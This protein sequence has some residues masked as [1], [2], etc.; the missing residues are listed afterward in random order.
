MI[1][2][3]RSAYPGTNK[4]TADKTT[5]TTLMPMPKIPTILAA[6]LTATAVALASCTVDTEHT[7]PTPVPVPTTTPAPTATPVAIPSPLPTATPVTIAF[8]TPLPTATPFV[9]PS[10]LPTATPAPTS[11][12][13][14]I[15]FP[16]PLPTA[17]PLAFRY[18]T[19]LPT[20]TPAPTS[21]PTS[22]EFPTP[23]PTATPFALNR[24]PID[25]VGG[26]EWLGDLDLLL[27]ARIAVPCPEL[28]GTKYGTAWH[29]RTD[30]WDGRML[31][32]ARHVISCSDGAP[33]REGEVFWPLD[34]YFPRDGIP[35]TVQA[36]DPDHDL[37]LLSVANLDILAQV[38]KWDIADASTSVNANMEV[39]QITTRDLILKTGDPSRVEPF[40]LDGIVAW[41]D[42]AEVIHT[43]IASMSGESGGLIVNAD[44]EAIGLITQGYPLTEAKDTS[45]STGPTTISTHF[46][47]IRQLL[48][49]AGFLNR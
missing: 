28:D 25:A 33:V 24:E 46:K 8:P 31:L 43:A 6:I 1:S 38:E 20:P 18:P 36:D 41:S 11:T 16:T 32:T 19:P 35:F 4:P 15:E 44:R 29:V 23:L 9:F 47:V 21:T 49:D 12:P 37:A 34:P 2:N 45:V 17:T 26:F 5:R 42:D 7:H 48:I 27:A 39:R 13:L 3:T 30:K 10:P 22:I 40:V 14:S